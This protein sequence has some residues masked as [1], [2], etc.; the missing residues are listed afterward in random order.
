MTRFAFL[1]LAGVVALAPALAAAA[2]KKNARKKNPAFAAVEDVAGLPRVLL[3][4]DSISIGYTVPTREALKGKANV[5]RPATNCG[6][7]TTGLAQ[8]DKWLGDGKWD[9]IH[10]NWGLHDLKYMGPN[11]EN[12]ADPKSP[13]SHQQV[14]PA[15]YEKNLR[16]LVARLKETGAK[17]IW[18]NTTPVPE[19]AAGRVV[20]DSAKYNDIAAKIMK[21]N[22][23]AI[24]DLYGYV[25]ERQDKI[26]LPANVHFTREGSGELGKEVARVI[27][28]AL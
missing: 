20:G 16:A 25:K 17:L 19:G 6:P 5:H 28:E 15:E 3:I 11:N 23:I 9:V 12:L 26:M 13:D 7:T 18:R 8:I 24:H 27:G 2:P 22:G 14:P 1:I 10:F 21:E 4:G